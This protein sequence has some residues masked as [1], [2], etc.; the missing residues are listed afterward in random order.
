MKISV[1]KT[2]YIVFNSD[3]SHSAN[4]HFS[5]SG[6]QLDQVISFKYLGHK[7]NERLNMEEHFSEK[8]AKSRAISGQISN[9][10]R[11]L[12]VKDP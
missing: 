2:K 12:N 4:I 1:D 9:L 3:S 6:I 8:L 10:M 11:D 5:V 7:I